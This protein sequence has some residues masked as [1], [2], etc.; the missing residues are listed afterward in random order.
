MNEF[1]YKDLNKL[2]SLSLSHIVSKAITLAAK[3]KFDQFLSKNT[4]YIDEVAKYCHFHPQATYRFLRIL[5]A[6][7]IVE[8][9]DNRQVKAGKLLPYLNRLLSPHFLDSYTFI[10]D[11]EFALQNNVECYSKMKMILAKT[12]L[13]KLISCMKIS[14]CP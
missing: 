12:N 1:N 13:R 7:E 5:D 11:L 6:Y 10:D 14:F 4:V 2:Y 9:V 8:F 3:I